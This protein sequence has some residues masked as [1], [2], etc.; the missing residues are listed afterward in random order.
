MS[1]S[2]T[3]KAI[4]HKVKRFSPPQ[5]VEHWVTEV[6]SMANKKVEQRNKIIFSNNSSAA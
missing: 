6:T 2:D 3:E 1:K 4:R 5:L